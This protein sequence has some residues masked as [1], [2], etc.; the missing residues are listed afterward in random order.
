ML[1]LVSPRIHCDCKTQ[2][3]FISSA[4]VGNTSL[5]LSIFGLSIYGG[6]TRGS[7][8]NRGADYS[9]EAIQH[10]QASLGSLGKSRHELNTE[11][12]E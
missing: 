2:Q 12:V 5:I 10:F 1:L 6:S 7:Q 11:L 8:Q 4:P 3:K 9:S